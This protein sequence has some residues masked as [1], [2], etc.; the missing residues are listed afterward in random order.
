MEIRVD[1]AVVA[2][3]TRLIFVTA[4]ALRT[5]VAARVARVFAGAKSGVVP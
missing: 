2:P 1:R 4:S 3:H 5:S